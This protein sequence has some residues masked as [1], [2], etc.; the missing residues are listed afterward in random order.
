MQLMNRAF[1][2]WHLWP[3]GV[4]SMSLVEQQ[5]QQQQKMVDVNVHKQIGSSFSFI[6]KTSQECKLPQTRPQA[7]KFN[8]QS[9]HI[10]LMYPR[11]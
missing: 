6:G 7:P 11:P 10:V 2:G 3:T 4:R 9:Y 1:D 8:P 5:Q